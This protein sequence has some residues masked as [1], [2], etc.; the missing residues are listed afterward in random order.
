[1]LRLGFRIS[2]LICMFGWDMGGEIVRWFLRL[3]LGAFL[4]FF[5]EVWGEAENKVKLVL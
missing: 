2:R 5:V 3:F 4:S 1:L